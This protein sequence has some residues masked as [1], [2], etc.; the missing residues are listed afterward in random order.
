MESTRQLKVARL[1]QKDLGDL[2]QRYSREHWH[3]NLVTVT[4]VH[5]TPDLSFAK[6]HL[7]LWG[8]TEKQ[9]LLTIIN[10]HKKEIRLALGKRIHNQI[11][12]IPEI[13][14]YLDD[15]LDYIEN[16]ENLLKN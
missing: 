6:V 10:E 1:I 4:K 7:S 8:K 11:R 15:S 13:A 2:L 3:G 16:I 14:F 5:V 12:V 9:E